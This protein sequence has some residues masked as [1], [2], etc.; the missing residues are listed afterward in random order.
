MGAGDQYRDCAITWERDVPLGPGDGQHRAA[1]KHNVSR[2]NHENEQLLGAYLN[3]YLGR[4][5][6]HPKPLFSFYMF[7]ISFEEWEHA[8][9]QVKM[10]M[11]ELVYWKFEFPTA[12]LKYWRVK[13]EQ[14]RRT[15]SK[16]GTNGSDYISI[17][18][19]NCFRRFCL[20][21][22]NNKHIFYVSKKDTEGPVFQTL[23]HDPLKK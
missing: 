2:V 7:C 10:N 22:N 23:Y 4:W 19:P 11:S 9:V 15:N 14:Q 16:L 21:Y 3:F 12:Y 18:K 17:I 13:S 1:E 6:H 8:E 5:I 20:D